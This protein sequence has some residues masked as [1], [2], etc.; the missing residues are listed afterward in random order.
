MHI[1]N[2][3]QKR[4]IEGS[5]P[6]CLTK[7]T[8]V[9]YRENVVNFNARPTQ[10]TSRSSPEPQTLKQSNPKEYI[11]LTFFKGVTVTI[12]LG[13]DRPTDRPSPRT[14]KDEYEEPF[15]HFPGHIIC[16]YSQTSYSREYFICFLQ[17]KPN[18]TTHHNRICQ[19][20]IQRRR[21]CECEFKSMRRP[22]R[23]AGRLS[24]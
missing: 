8:E 24:I 11:L 19:T 14:I 6:K 23:G 2:A 9:R 21:K 10:R 5:H 1:K 17:N 12:H 22:E 3:P 15:E 16:N 13:S 7:Q 18:K 4:F 20:I